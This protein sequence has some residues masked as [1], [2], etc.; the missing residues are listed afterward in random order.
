MG[1]TRQATLRTQPQVDQPFLLFSSLLFSPLSLSQAQ[2]PPRSL[3][4]RLTRLSRRA[5]QCSASRAAST[6]RG[7]LHRLPRR[8]RFSLSPPLSSPLA[9]PRVCSG[10]PRRRPRGSRQR[11]PCGSC[12]GWARQSS[13]PSR[14]SLRCADRARRR[15]RG[16]E[17]ERE[18]EGK[19]RD[20]KRRKCVHLCVFLCVF[21]CRKRARE[22]AEKQR[23]NKQQDQAMTPPTRR[24]DGLASRTC[25]HTT[26]TIDPAVC[27]Q[28]RRRRTRGAP[29][30]GRCLRFVTP[31]PVSPHRRVTSCRRLPP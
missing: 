22:C 6:R 12:S 9:R 15:E 29:V 26:D 18:Q 27:R 23:R 21:V 31:P 5:S 11:G 14:P 4:S 17:R 20:E 25:S 3:S 7:S 10:G 2:P 30:R 19:E 28:R 24:G 1:E 16:E 8:C 13:S